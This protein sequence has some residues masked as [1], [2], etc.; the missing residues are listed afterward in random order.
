MSTELELPEGYE[1]KVEASQISIKK[2]NSELV[3]RFPAQKMA[4]R[5]EN[6]K[7]IIDLKFKDAK[8]RALLGTFKAHI[9]NMLAG[10]K[11]EF[12]YKLKICSVHF[13]MNVQVKGN[14]LSI[15]NFIGGKK[16]RN[17]KIPPSVDISVKGND[18]LVKSRDIELAGMA[19]ARI[20][21]ITR[22]SKKDRRVFQD[23]IFMVEKAGKVI[24]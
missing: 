9:K 18:I 20:E 4:I 21:Q 3:R 24:R 16:A 11:E 5:V 10:L 19:A 14:E 2:E 1:A 8:T 12:V 6:K 13:P 7:I 22:L 17:I 15:N 23:G